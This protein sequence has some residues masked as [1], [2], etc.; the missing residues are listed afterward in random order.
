VTDDDL[1]MYVLNGLGP[2][3]NSFVVSITTSSR[4][5]PYTYPELH[6]S[7]MSYENL[8][9]GQNL[10]NDLLHT[11][12]NLAALIAQNRPGQ[13][14]S[15]YNIQTELNYNNHIRSNQN[16]NQNRSNYNA[17]NQPIKPP[18]PGFNSNSRYGPPTP[19]SNN[20]RLPLALLGVRASVDLWHAR[21]GHPSSSITLHLLKT[22]NL[23]C[24]SNKLS[25][26]HDCLLAKSHKLHF[27]P[28]N[29]TSTLPLEL[30]HSDVWGPCRVASFNDFQFYIIFVD[31]FSRF[32]WIY[33]LE[34]KSEV[35]HIF[36]CFKAQAENLLSHNIKTLRTDEGT[37]YLPITKWF[38]HIIHQT[39]CPYTPKQNG[40]AERKHRH[41]IE[42][43]LAIMSR[44]SL[45]PIY[46]DEIFSSVIYLI[47]RLP[48]LSNS[49]KIP[50][51]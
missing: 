29:S 15:N 37:K 6:T 3:F 4:H 23:S 10:S 5:Q 38:P 33:F 42:L 30:V 8:L 13:N 43:T 35:P 27:F 25:T 39:T 40:L 32:T 46:W 31:D 24:N 1:V 20:T 36:S 48:S 51:T 50:Y 47:N 28:S 18:Y 45:P 2:E 44:A 16:H 12:N 49:G 7:L 21:L 22:S 26:Y 14:R 9:Q 17:Q 34:N 11:P 41:I 19:Q